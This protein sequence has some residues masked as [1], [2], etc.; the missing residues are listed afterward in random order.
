MIKSFSNKI[1]YFLINNKS[2]N[3]EDSEVCSYGMEVLISSFINTL[4]VLVI[5]LIFDKFIETVVFIVCYCSIR[6]FSGGYHASTHGKC[7]FTFL[8]MYLMTIFVA[9]NTYSIHLKPVVVLI[10]ILNW[11]SIYLLVPVQH[12]NNPLSNVE[13]IRHKK[14]ARKVVSLVL[15]G[16]FIGSYLYRGYEYVLYAVLALCWVNFMLVLQVIKNKGEN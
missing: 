10:G 7:I 12:L 13:K 3:S 4:M 9:E 16:I 5:G 11:I 2:L 8:C 1:T 15:I 6:Q 14:S